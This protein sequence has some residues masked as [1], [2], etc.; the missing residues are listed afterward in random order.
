MPLELMEQRLALDGPAGQLAAQRLIA[1]GANP[2]QQCG[3]GQAALLLS[4]SSRSASWA[5][6]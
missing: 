4:S 5:A 6:S 3:A 2:A 1:L